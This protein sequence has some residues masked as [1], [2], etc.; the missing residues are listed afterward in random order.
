MK[1]PKETAMLTAQFAELV[2][3]VPDNLR[4]VV[5]AQLIGTVNG[6]LIAASIDQEKQTA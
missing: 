5:T 6:V 3:Q 4:D 1:T 2:A